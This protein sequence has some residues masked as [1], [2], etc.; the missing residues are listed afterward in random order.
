MHGIDAFSMLT[1]RLYLVFC[2]LVQNEINWFLEIIIAANYLD[3]PSLVDIGTTIIAEQIVGKE[4][5]EVATYFGQE[6]RMEELN[7][8]LESL[9]LP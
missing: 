7:E 9:K 8:T 3:I 4:P 1:G 5:L 2:S 6:H